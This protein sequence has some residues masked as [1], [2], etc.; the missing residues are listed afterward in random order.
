M[1]DPRAETKPERRNSSANRA[2]RVD[3]PP[4][5]SHMAPDAETTIGRQR[6]D[7]QA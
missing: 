2:R 7:P 3:P 4:M 1:D 6:F 5:A